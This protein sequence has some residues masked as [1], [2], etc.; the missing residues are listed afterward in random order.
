ML[1]TTALRASCVA[2]SLETLEMLLCLHV[3][4]TTR[5][6]CINSYIIRCTWRDQAPGVGV[7]ATS[8]NYMEGTHTEIHQVIM[9]V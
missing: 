1:A 4:S 6:K 8:R 3:A 9:S 7:R 5:K 2:V